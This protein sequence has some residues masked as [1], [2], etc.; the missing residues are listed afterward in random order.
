M[1]S[2]IAFRSGIW[3]N[4]TH[5]LPELM[6]SQKEAISL[7]LTGFPLPS[8]LPGFTENRVKQLLNTEK[9]ISRQINRLKG[10]LDGC[11]NLS[12][13]PCWPFGEWPVGGRVLTVVESQHT[14]INTSFLISRSLALGNWIWDYDTVKSPPL[15][16]N[17]FSDKAPDCVPPARN[18]RVL[19][20]HCISGWNT[21]P[22]LWMLATAA[23]VQTS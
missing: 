7:Y 2:Y 6:L 11:E 19:L 17:V 14:T 8:L 12:R 13:M 22:M 1:G 16:L 15:F 23:S 20:E 4:R 21:A 10:G 3:S 5:F 9:K 18:I